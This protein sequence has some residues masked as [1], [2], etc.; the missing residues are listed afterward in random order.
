VGTP[1][2]EKRF[3]IQGIPSTI[4]LDRN[5]IIR[6]RVVGFEYTSVFESALQQLL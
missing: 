1:E 6:K 2:A 4:L 5:G 3:G